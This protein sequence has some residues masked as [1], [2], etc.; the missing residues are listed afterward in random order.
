MHSDCIYIVFY[1]M[2]VGL[3]TG[4]FVGKFHERVKWNELI[5]AGILPKPRVRR[6]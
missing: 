6:K 2:F 3:A 5:K 1:A 4:L